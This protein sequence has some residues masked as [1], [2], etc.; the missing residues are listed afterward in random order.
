MKEQVSVSILNKDQTVPVEEVSAGTLHEKNG[1]H[2][3][4]LENGDRLIWTD[5]EL[6]VRRRGTE[7]LFRN[8]SSLSCLYPT[9]LGA[10]PLTFEGISLSVRK[11]E[12]GHHIE[13]F[14]R[15]SQNGEPGY[16]ASLIIKI[17]ALRRIKS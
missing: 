1:K 11:T 17:C 5:T 13:L 2:Y 7:L 14:Y 3:C 16:D 15:I 8:E 9:E 10:I 6:S 4:F 12:D